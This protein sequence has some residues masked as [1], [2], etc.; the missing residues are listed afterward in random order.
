MRRP[1]LHTLLVLSSLVVV[2]GCKE[3]EEEQDR[4][5]LIAR[6][7]IG[8]EGGMLSGGGATLVVPPGAVTRET[9]F[10]LR[11]FSS[12]LSARD[13]EQ[14]APP[15][16][17]FPRGLELRLPAELSFG[18]GP[19]HPAVLF[20]QDG[21]TVAAEGT[22]AFIN[23]LNAFGL[24][25]AGTQRVDLLEPML[26]PSPDKAG[27][28]IRDLARFELALSEI[29]RLNVVL[30]VYDLA[31]AYDKPLNGSGNGDCGFRLERV[32][33]GSLAAGCSDMP[34]T[35]IVRVT[36]AQVGFDVVP[37]LAGKMETPVTVGM[38]AGGDDLA[39]HL[40]FFSFDTSACFEETCS[41]RGECED[42]GNGAQC[43]CDE[44]YAPA[45]LECECVPQCAGRS[46]GN[47][48]CG[49]QCPP[50]CGDGAS[51]ME[52]SCVPDGSNDDGNDDG[53]DDGN[54]STSNDDGMSDSSTGGDGGSTD[55][56]G[57][58]S[59]SG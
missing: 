11:T 49:G 27:A 5:S 25:S 9:D 6:Q 7:T 50:G 57:S 13:Y 40:G 56:G 58:G 31:N 37:F 29:P 30:T 4:G 53:T 51:C 55:D 24:A 8:P 17:L 2:S 45:G 19:E 33:G 44:G 38:V 54:G 16:E 10:E 28:P 32:Q 23:E 39:Y 22:T 34:T 59:T 18:D 47:D 3:E 35:S 26:M 42:V 41:G 1:S 46:C 43:V 20:R 12:S 48:S 15:M 36:S 14:V 21:L 52:G